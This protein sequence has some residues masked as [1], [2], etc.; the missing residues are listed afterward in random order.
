MIARY[1]MHEKLGLMAYEDERRVF[2]PGAPPLSA[3]RA[4]SEY[5][6]CEIDC[7]VREALQRAFDRAAGVLASAR[8]ILERGARLLLEKE[9]LGEA[10]LGKLREALAATPAAPA[11]DDIRASAA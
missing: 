9:T 11:Q 8:E 10:E 2:L 6:A 3:E 5:T 1:G 4:Y 7:A